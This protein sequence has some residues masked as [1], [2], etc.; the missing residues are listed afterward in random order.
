MRHVLVTG[1]TGF[2]GSHLVAKLSDKG[3][4]VRCLVQETSNR[5]YL[6]KYNIEY[7]FGDLT[8]ADSLHSAI[9]GID[10]IFH[11]AGRVRSQNEDEFYKVNVTGTVNL[12]KAIVTS[13]IKLNRFVFVSSLAAAGPSPDGKPV[14]E[15][16]MSHP[17]S[18]YGVSKLAAEDAVMA[19]SSHIPITIVRPPIVYGP[20]DL[21]VFEIFQMVQSHIKPVLGWLKRYASIIYVDDLVEALFLTVESEKSDGEIYFFASGCVSWQD[22]NN[23]IAHVL[24]K[25]AVTV[26]IPITL[27]MIVIFFIEVICKIRGKTPIVNMIKI[28]ELKQRFWICDSS[29]AESKLGYLSKI[30][31]DEGLRKT[32]EWYKREGWLK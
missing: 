5:D 9:Q 24:N 12:L 14:T 8:N 13:H 4:H 26:H 21:G 28:R 20:R 10:T 23:T 29:K 2:I 3:V 11:L 17:I 19:F 27:L 7:I 30:P 1:G 25:K 18:P 22:L 31:L 16:D 6:D 32:A 15:S